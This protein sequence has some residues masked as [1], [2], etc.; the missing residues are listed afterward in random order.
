MQ[1]PVAS[2]VEVPP[3]VRLPLGVASW[4]TPPPSG[5]LAFASEAR[6]EAA[7]DAVAV[8]R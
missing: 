1:L 3:P 8:E 5:G 6:S 7:L 4:V 2:P